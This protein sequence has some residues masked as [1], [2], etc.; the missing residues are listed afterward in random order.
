MDKTL[1]KSAEDFN[2]WKS[3]CKNVAYDYVEFVAEEEEEPKEYPCVMI[4]HD[5]P[6]CEGAYKYYLYYHFVY[7]SDFVA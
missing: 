2:A 7:P 4:S 3:Y 1:L 5:E 6:V